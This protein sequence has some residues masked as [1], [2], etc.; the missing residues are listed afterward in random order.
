M[1]ANQFAAIEQ[2]V[3]NV[4]NEHLELITV[5]AKSLA[6][7]KNRAAK[8][9]VATSI[10]STFLKQFEDDIA[11]TKT[12]TEAQYAHGIG[13][14]EGKNITEKKVNV[15]LFKDYTDARET[16]EKLE[17]FKNWVKTHTK[18]FENAHL[19]FRQYSRD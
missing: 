3:S 6:D 5:D 4:I 1:E 15:A 11:R 17:S 16:L 13:S 14:A 9:L 10:L 12:L 7:A 8:F 2:S 18:I 19:M